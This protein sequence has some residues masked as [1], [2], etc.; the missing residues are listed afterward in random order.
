[1]SALF[2][3]CLSTFGPDTKISAQI[4]TNPCEHVKGETT[5]K[6]MVFCLLALQKSTDS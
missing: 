4:T 5:A 3:E 1:M 2:W 6:K